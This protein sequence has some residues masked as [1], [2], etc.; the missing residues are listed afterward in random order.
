MTRTQIYMRDERS[1][2]KIIPTQVDIIQ[3]KRASIMAQTQDHTYI[4][5][6]PIR[7]DGLE[8]VTGKANFGADTTQPGMLHGAVLR[9]PHA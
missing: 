7:P 1:S 2:I 5:T 3:S 4:G 8:K 6:R 9:S